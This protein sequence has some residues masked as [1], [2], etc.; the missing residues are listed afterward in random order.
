MTDPTTVPEVLVAAA[1]HM[2]RYGWI[3]HGYCAEDPGG[4]RACSV[5]PR[6]AIAVV[7]SGNPLYFVDWP[8]HCESPDDPGADASVV[9]AELAD[10]A[11]IAATETA[12]AGYLLD[13]GVTR[14]SFTEH[15]GP[16]ELIEHW[17][18]REDQTLP[19][20]LGAMRAAAE[21]GR[22]A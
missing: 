10:Y 12:L 4:P 9:E 7:V 21:R 1:D 17:A 5:C 2:Q 11:L 13:Q 6:G 3:Q 15:T 18:D 16:G 22:T 19:K 14:L 20:I 8:V